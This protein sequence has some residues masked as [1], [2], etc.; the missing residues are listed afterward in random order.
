MAVLSDNARLQI[1]RALQ[2]YWSNLREL[3]DLNKSDLLAAIVATDEYIDSIAG[4]YN[5]ALPVAARDNLTALQKTL[6]FSVVAL[7]R[8][9]GGAALVRRLLGVEVD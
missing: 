7:A 3:L 5:S 6:L 8:V 2:R 9:G 4:A 1:W